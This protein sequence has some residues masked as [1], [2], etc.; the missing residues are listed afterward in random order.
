LIK[1]AKSATCGFV[2]WHEVKI[3]F[4]AKLML[5]LA[6]YFGTMFGAIGLA[7][8]IAGDDKELN[9]RLA[10]VFVAVWFVAWLVI[11]NR[12]GSALDY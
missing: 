6:L 3:V 4:I 12:N 9:K 11:Y 7:G 1:C 8:Y 10:N 5:S 2:K